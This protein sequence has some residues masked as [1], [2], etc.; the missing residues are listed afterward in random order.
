MDSYSV[1]IDRAYLEDRTV[2]TLSDQSIPFAG[3]IETNPKVV[4]I[5]PVKYRDALTHSSHQETVIR[6]PHDPVAEDPLISIAIP[7]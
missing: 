5:V 3:G 1:S 6:N 7:A 2:K 4:S